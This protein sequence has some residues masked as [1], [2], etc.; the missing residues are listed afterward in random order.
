MPALARSPI[1]DLCPLASGDASTLASFGHLLEASSDAVEPP[2]HGPKMTLSPYE[3]REVYLPVNKGLVNILHWSGP[4][5]RGWL[6]PSL[7]VMPS[8][9]PQQ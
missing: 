3:N 9:R 6:L 5:S 7:H 1:H 2:S 8:T 4:N